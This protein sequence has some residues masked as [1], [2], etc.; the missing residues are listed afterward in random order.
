[1][2]KKPDKPQPDNTLYLL[3]PGGVR[4]PVKFDILKYGGGINLI[5]V[6]QESG[7]HIPL[8]ANASTMMLELQGALHRIELAV[9][10]NEQVVV[11]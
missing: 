10:Q 9:E 4:I 1:M 8:L 6:N 7:V 3:R 2:S 11:K 5:L